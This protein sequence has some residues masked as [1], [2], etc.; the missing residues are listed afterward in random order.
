MAE[1]VGRG[2]RERLAL[3]K[4]E[5][6]R[7]HVCKNV[8]APNCLAVASNGR[9]WPFYFEKVATRLRFAFKVKV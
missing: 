5:T 9:E 8:A 3:S 7:G 1:A 2:Y 6:K 4:R